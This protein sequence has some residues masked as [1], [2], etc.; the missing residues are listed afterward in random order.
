MIDTHSHIY[1]SQF[2]EDLEAV[3]QRASDVG[4]TDIF[5]P[6]IDFSS[7]EDME[8]LQHPSINFYKMAGIHP[9]D[10]KELPNNFE[11]RLSDWCQKMTFMEWEKLG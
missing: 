10:V 5:M 6:A 4:I 3:L 9:A 7:L 11:Q 2:Q 8:N 1:L